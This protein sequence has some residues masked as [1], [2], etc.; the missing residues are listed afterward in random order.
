MSEHTSLSAALR[1]AMFEEIERGAVYNL[2]RSHAGVLGDA[3]TQFNNELE[4]SGIGYLALTAN[5]KYYF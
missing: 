5:L 3:V 2:L 1:R 4:F